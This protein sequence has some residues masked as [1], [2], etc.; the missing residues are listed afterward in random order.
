MFKKNPLKIF[1]GAFVLKTKVKISDALDNIVAAALPFG[2]NFLADLKKKGKLKF[3]KKYIPIYDIGLS[4]NFNST[5]NKKEDLGLIL[6]PAV[7]YGCSLE[8][9]S[10]TKGNLS[11]I[12][13]EISISDIR[14][15]PLL[16]PLLSWDDYTNELLRHVN[17][18]NKGTFTFDS[19]TT[20]AVLVPVLRVECTYQH[21]S[22]V[23][24]ANLYDGYF[25]DVHTLFVDSKP[26]SSRPEADQKFNKLLKY[27]ELTYTIKKVEF[28]VFAISTILTTILSF[29]PMPDGIGTDFVSMLLFSIMF[30][31]PEFLILYLPR[32]SRDKQWSR[33]CN[34]RSD[35]QYISDKGQFTMKAKSYQMFGWV[36]IIAAAPLA[37]ITLFMALAMVSGLFY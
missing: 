19:I 34:Y 35:Y 5:P 28:L 8:I 31:V 22:Y 11:N 9:S 23:F 3:Q 17:S 37:L 16:C 21:K 26:S 27:K 4:G 33:I 14:K 36:Q 18:L 30:G 7:A 6:N 13:Q 15:H 32:K 2:G 24:Y 20:I 1:D 29:F 25:V 10:Y 12:L